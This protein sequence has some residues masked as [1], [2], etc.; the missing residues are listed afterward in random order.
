MC[1]S[2]RGKFLVEKNFNRNKKSLRILEAFWVD[3]G[4]RTHDP[5]NHN[6]ML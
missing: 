4:I 3:D 6:P 1:N 5:R 2:H